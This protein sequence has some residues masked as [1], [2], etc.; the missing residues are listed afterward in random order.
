MRKKKKYTGL[1]N[2]HIKATFNNTIVTVCDN[3]GSVLGWASSGTSGFKGTR[4]STAFAA[5]L[6]AKNA[7]SQALEMGV[8]RIQI[9]LRGSG[10]GRES[11]VR[12]LRQA[13][14]HILS[15]EDKTSVPF[16]GCRPPRRRKL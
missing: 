14:L 7:A 2:I 6:A 5:Q 4:K 3:L 12:A 9:V 13:G 11:A 15:I 10:N 16:N 1:A 8:R